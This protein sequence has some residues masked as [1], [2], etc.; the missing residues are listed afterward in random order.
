MNKKMVKKQHSISME[1]FLRDYCHL[2]N[3]YLIEMLSGLSHKELK[4]VCRDIYKL[5]LMTLPFEKVSVE[6]V[7][8][9]EVVFVND[10]FYNPAPYKNPRTKNI[11]D[12]VMLT[13]DNSSDDYSDAELYEDIVDAIE[14]N[15]T[16]ED[17]DI[18]SVGSFNL[19]KV[20]T[21]GGMKN[22]KY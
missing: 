21:K 13:K 16:I 12:M 4:D 5:R 10:A 22:D 18:S 2:E 7:N 15:M 19:P 11:D 20:K 6:E 8:C 9:G 17:A 14:N 1:K 3:D